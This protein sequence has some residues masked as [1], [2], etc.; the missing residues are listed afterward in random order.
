M[1]ECHSTNTFALD[2]CQQPSAPADGTLIIT[3]NQTAGRG[4]RGK[5]WLAESGKNLT[6]SI[7]LKPRFLS[8]R[9]Q[10][11]L[12][13]FSSLA[14]RDYLVL[15]HCDKVRIKWPNDVY[16]RDKKVCGMLIE[17]QL[18]GNQFNATILGIGLNINQMSFA[19]PTAIS[20]AIEKQQLF[21]LPS[22]LEIL[23]PLIES[24]YLQLRQGSLSALMDE[25]LA[26]LY[27]IHEEHTFRNVSLGE[28]K[29]TITGIDGIGHLKVSA[30]GKELLF[31]VKELEY[32]N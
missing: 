2:L 7:V 11:Y 23:L 10:Y 13:I 9:D 8:I 20:L 27:W 18:S 24:R 25:Y 15:H 5:E 28:F 22:E 6:F 19:L 26:S 1:P 12:N 4:Q 30:Q 31:D 3:S 32:V 29:G 17:N 21:D 16:I 14:I